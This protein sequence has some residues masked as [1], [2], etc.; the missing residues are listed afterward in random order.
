MKRI[1]LLFTALALV[2]APVHAQNILNNLKNRAKNAA[3]RNLGNKVEKGVNDILNGVLGSDNGQQAQQQA[4]QQPA[5]QQPQQ[6]KPAA[7]A[8]T[9]Q[10]TTA[11]NLNFGG[12]LTQ[13]S[14]DVYENDVL[15][16]HQYIDGSMVYNES[17]KGNSFIIKNNKVYILDAQ[18][19]TATVLSLEDAAKTGGGAGMDR[20]ITQ[21]LGS[22]TAVKSE[23]EK[24]M[25][26]PEVID[27]VECTHYI[28]YTHTAQPA[29]IDGQ[30][31]SNAVD[32]DHE[33]WEHPQWG[34]A[35]QTLTGQSIK[36]N[37]KNIVP[38][39]QPKEKF[40]IPAGYK[41]VDMTD[42]F[43]AL[44]KAMQNQ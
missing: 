3:E 44:M 23:V 33:V 22:E 15:S 7:P 36:L 35:L 26:E 4:G 17:V 2:C 43:G 12:H 28:A 13:Y 38:G 8:T 37:Y 29:T 6:Q 25:L 42:A 20:Q 32:S 27:G 31:R 10:N 16:A 14:C 1:L 18:K 24:K 11:S 39:P 21:W 34:I 40:E 5:Q 9:P 41:E 30:Q 19:K